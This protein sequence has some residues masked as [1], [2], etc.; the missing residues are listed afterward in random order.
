MAKYMVRGVID[1]ETDG[2][3]LPVEALSAIVEFEPISTLEEL[4]IEPLDID[5]NEG[6][7]S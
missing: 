2:K 6:S 3:I 7:Y 1:I 5:R 4:T